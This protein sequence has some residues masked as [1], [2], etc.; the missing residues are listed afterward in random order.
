MPHCKTIQDLAGWRG[1]ATN[2]AEADPSMDND[3]YLADL[4]AVNLAQRMK[5]GASLFEASNEYYPNAE[6]LRRDEFIANQGDYEKVQ[7]RVLK[8]MVPHYSE[9]TETEA[10][11]YLK[12]YEPVSYNF[13]MSLKMERTNWFNML[14]L[15]NSKEMRCEKKLSL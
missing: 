11:E 6:R 12:Q 13:L 4:D 9:L 8:S 7:N 14:I 5:N 10:M 15:I 2:D 3:D 1:D